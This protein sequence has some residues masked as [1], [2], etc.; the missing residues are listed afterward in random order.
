MASRIPDLVVDSKLEVE[1]FEDYSIQTRLVS[2]PAT[3]QRRTLQQERWQRTKVLGRGT[4]GVVWLEKC[5]TGPSLGKLRAVK[6]IIKQTASASATAY[7][8]ELEAI[9]KFS[10][11]KVG[12]HLGKFNKQGIYT[13]YA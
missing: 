3:G 11:E 12:S 6:E 2:D 13:D 8:R 7:S 10:Q 1:C 5:A 4:F 9:A